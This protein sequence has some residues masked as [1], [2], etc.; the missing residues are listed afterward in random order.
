MA[1]K[2]KDKPGTV[3]ELTPTVTDEFGGQFVE[4]VSGKHK[5]KR[6]AVISP[7]KRDKDGLVTAG[8]LRTR[9]DDTQRIPVDYK[10]LRITLSTGR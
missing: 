4:V 10:D 8:L 5:G 1:A 2:A 9:D 6:G 7:L 3:G